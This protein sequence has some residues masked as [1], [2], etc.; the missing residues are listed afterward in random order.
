MRNALRA[1]ILLALSS[2]VSYPIVQKVAFSPAPRKIAVLAF[3]SG[4]I[5]GGIVGVP[6][7]VPDLS[8]PYTTFRQ[9]LSDSKMFVIA[10]DQTVLACPMYQTLPVPPITMD[11]NAALL[12]PVQIDSARVPAVAQALGADVVIVV[13][14]VPYVE[15]GFQVGGIGSSHV[16]VKTFLDAYAAN[17][18]PIWKDIFV[19]DSSGFASAGVIRDPGAVQKAAVEAISHATQE[20]VGRLTMKLAKS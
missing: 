14:Y 1:S 5:A 13:H 11:S 19:T 12:R 8:V 18:A 17:G 10:T 15:A 3:H 16:A 20:A 6:L 9:S 4:L 2:C 7:P